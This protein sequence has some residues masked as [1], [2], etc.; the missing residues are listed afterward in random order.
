MVVVGADCATLGAAGITAT[1]GPTY[2]A[3]LS[4]VDKPIWSLYPG[5]VSSPTVTAG[6]NDEVYPS[7]TEAPVLVCMEQTGQSR[8]DCHDDILQSNNGSSSAAT[9]TT[10]TPGS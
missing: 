2:C 7:E 1:G 3:H 9:S 10:T 6:P 4:T 8:L 5:E